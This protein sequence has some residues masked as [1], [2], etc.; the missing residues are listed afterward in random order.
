V[1]AGVV[2]AIVSVLA[3][4]VVAEGVVSVFSSEPEQAESAKI[5]PAK[6]ASQS[7]FIKHLDQEPEP[8]AATHFDAAPRRYRTHGSACRSGRR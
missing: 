7:F 6:L 2:G 4:G 5:T 1:V 3:G 8:A